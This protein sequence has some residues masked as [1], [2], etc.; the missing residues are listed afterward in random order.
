VRY[1]VFIEAGGRLK[2]TTGIEGWRDPNTY[3][4]REAAEVRGENLTANGL[5]AGAVGWRVDEVAP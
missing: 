2:S 4:T 5:P 3:A 1:Q